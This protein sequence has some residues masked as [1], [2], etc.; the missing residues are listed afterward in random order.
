MKLHEI[1]K[2]PLQMVLE[3]VPI[4]DLHNLL[5]SET[6]SSLST[7][8]RVKLALDCASGMKYVSKG[9]LICNC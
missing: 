2:S 6:S 9:V 7:K 4:S 1:T 8:W 3:F 5:E